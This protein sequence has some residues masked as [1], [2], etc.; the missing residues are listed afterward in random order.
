MTLLLWI[1]V[2]IVVIAAIIK[3]MK[4]NVIVIHPGMD[5]NNPDNPNTNTPFQKGFPPIGNVPNGFPGHGFPNQHPQQEQGRKPGNGTEQMVCCEHCNVFIP[6][7][8]S[9]KRAG[10]TFCSQEHAMAWFSSDHKS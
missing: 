1:G 8:Q 9:I 4:E 6:S 2:V 3:N 7:S 10:H 5:P